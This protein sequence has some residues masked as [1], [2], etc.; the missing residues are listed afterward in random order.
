MAI[1]IKKTFSSKLLK[2][3]LFY[4]F[5]TVVVGAL[6]VLLHWV[7]SRAM[8]V[9]EYGNFQGYISLFTIVS[10]LGSAI[11]YFVVRNSTR[12]VLNQDYDAS[13]AL[14]GWILRK[15][16][17]VSVVSLLV[18]LGVWAAWGYYRGYLLS[19]GYVLVI[20]AAFANFRTTAYLAALSAWRRFDL[21]N[22]V[23]L[24][25]GLGKL[26]AG[27]AL[28]FLTRR[29]AF[30]V[31]AFLASEAV[32]LF[33]A[34]LLNRRVIGQAAETAAWADWRGYVD[35]TALRRNV[36]FVLFFSGIMGFLTYG[37]IFLVRQFT[38]ADLTGHYGVLSLLGKVML[39]VN[40]SIVAV[41]FPSVCAKVEQE[42]TSSSMETGNPLLAAYL[43]I[44][45]VSLVAIGTCYLFPGLLIVR[46]FGAKYAPYAHLLWLFGLNAFALSILTLEANLT[47]ARQDR[48]GVTVLA[49]V[50]AC[51]ALGVWFSEKDLKHIAVTILSVLVVG[52]VT[53][54][55]L[56][57]LRWRL[58]RRLDSFS[59]TP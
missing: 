31:L 16:N 56:N 55:A 11:S 49:T 17:L 32:G 37:D 44:A 27:I 24:L 10:V 35:V 9:M 52:H 48:L 42:K 36:L 47:Y 5:S 54:V 41:A 26:I 40:M 51:M 43:L 30:V 23:F 45:A 59:P 7:V 1:K 53:V 38:S 57:H 20:F 29:A 3:S 39:W 22:F 58:Q 50:A 4:S 8:P 33:A 21:V 12:L 15:L 34:R 28:V 14:V 46:V 13:R 18:V 6:S 19:L 25:Q 2:D